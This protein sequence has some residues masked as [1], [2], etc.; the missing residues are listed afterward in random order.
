M[1]MEMRGKKRFKRR[2]QRI[3][4]KKSKSIEAECLRKTM[5]FFYFFFVIILFKLRSRDG[6]NISKQNL[7]ISICNSHSDIP[8]IFC[9]ELK[10]DSNI[11]DNS[12]R[13]KYIVLI[14]IIIVMTMKLKLELKQKQRK[15]KN[16]K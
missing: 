10:F 6:E 8:N 15:I 5:K 11:T 7:T 9:F 1:R 12:N 4:S 3:E 2:E 16:K 13:N 14:V